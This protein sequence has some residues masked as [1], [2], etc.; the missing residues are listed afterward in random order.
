MIISKFLPYAGEMHEVRVDFEDL[1]VLEGFKWS[2]TN[3]SRHPG[4]PKFYLRRRVWENGRQKEVVYFHR[5]VTG[6]LPGVVVDHLDGNGLN[7]THQ[8][9]RITTQAENIKAHRQ[10]RRQRVNLKTYGEK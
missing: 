8:N 10:K 6:A 9:F 7:D 3:C 2:I 5:Q 1:A 4:C